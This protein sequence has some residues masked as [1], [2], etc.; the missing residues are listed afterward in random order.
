MAPMLKFKT[1]SGKQGLVV[2]EVSTSLIRNHGFEPY[3]GHNH[4]SI[5]D[6]K[7]WLVP[8]GTLEIDLKQDLS[9]I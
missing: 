4:V 9:H 6:A 1:R 8:G 7:N 2:A 3:K 5:Y